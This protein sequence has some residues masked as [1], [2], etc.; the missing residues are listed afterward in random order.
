MS[1]WL[2][3]STTPLRLTKR[4]SGFD[5]VAIAPT[6]FNDW[7]EVIGAMLRG[8]S[9]GILATKRCDVRLAI[10]HEHCRHWVRDFYQLLTLD[11]GEVCDFKC[12]SRN[13]THILDVERLPTALRN[14]A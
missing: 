3:P 1:N 7:L 6:C 9:I 11:S 2:A 12:Y 10:T 5:Q 4:P 14:I 13:G 8:I